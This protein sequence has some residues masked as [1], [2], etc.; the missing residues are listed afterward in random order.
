MKA[1]LPGAAQVAAKASSNS[2]PDPTR[3]AGLRTRYDRAAAFGQ[4]RLTTS[5]VTGTRATTPV[6]PWPG[7]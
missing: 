3:L 2:A 1:P 7:G 5:T 4:T 6:T